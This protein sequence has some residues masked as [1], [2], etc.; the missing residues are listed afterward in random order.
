VQGVPIRVELGPRDLKDGQFVTVRRDTGAKLS[1][2]RAEAVT[3]ISKQL[4]EI[5]QNMFDK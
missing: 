3:L 4:D 2:Q 5:Q 1:L